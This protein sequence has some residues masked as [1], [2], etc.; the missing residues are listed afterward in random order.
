MHLRV[1]G[2]PVIHGTDDIT[3]TGPRSIAL[4]ELLCLHR[5]AAVSTDRIAEVLWSDRLPGNVDNAIQARVAALRRAFARAG[6]ADP[7]VTEER[8]YRL[9]VDPGGVD[10]DR[11]EQLVADGRR[12]VGAG[13]N[14]AAADVL[15]AALRLWEAAP[16]AAL[17]DDPVARGEVARLEEL[18]VAAQR[19]CLTADLALGRTD[20]VI[21]EA[22][23]LVGLHPFDEDLHALLITALYRAGRQTDALEA[24]GAITRRLRD[25]LGVDPGPA[26][27]QLHQQVLRHDHGLGPVPGPDGA[28]DGASGSARVLPRPLS[29]LVGRTS[30]LE[31]LER[32]CGEHR[33]V[34]LT[35]PGGIGKTRLAIAVAQRLVDAMEVDAHLVELGPVPR[36]AAVLDAVARAIGISSAPTDP[37]GRPVA[38]LAQRVVRGVRDRALVV[39]V[40]NCEHV[41]DGAV[42]AVELLLDAGAE[43]RV[44]ATSREGL[45]IAG[46]HLWPVTPLALP[47]P[48]TCDPDEV[49]QVASVRLFSDRARAASPAFVLD[50]HTAPAVVELVRRLDGLPLAI[51]LAAARLSSVTL[52]MLVDRLGDRFALLTGGARTATR[53]QQTLE[54]VIDWS[55]DLLDT[56]Q[57]AV[58]RRIGVFSSPAEVDAAEAVCADTDVPT[59]SVL[60]V[61]AELVD[62]SL[63]TLDTTG[64]SPRYGMLETIRTYARQRLDA[65]HARAP[66]DRHLA[67]YDELAASAAT[68]VRGGEQVAWLDRLDREHADLVAATRWAIRTEAGRALRMCN[69][70]AWTWWL[71]DHGAEG[72]DLLVAAVDASTEELGDA[73]GADRAVA[74]AWLAFLLLFQRSTPDAIHDV[75]ARV[76]AEARVSSLDDRAAAIV[77]IIGGFVDLAANGDPEV[78]LQAIEAGERHAARAGDEWALAAAAY[79]RAEALGTLGRADE[80]VQQARRAA[81]I[82]A[83]TGD[84]W[85]QF[86]SHQWQGM[87]AALTGAYAAAV[88]HYDQAA[89]L[90]DQLGLGD[91]ASGLGARRAMARMLDGEL[92]A[93][94]QDL[95]TVLDALGGADPIATGVTHHALGQ[96]AHRQGDDATSI[97]HHEVALA[98]FSSIGEDGACGEVHAHIAFSRA[99]L[100]DMAGATADARRALDLTRHDDPLSM[101][102]AAEGAAAAAARTAP[103]LAARFLGRA[104]ALREGQGL[105]LVAGE[106]HDVAIVEAQVRHLAGE[107]VLVRGMATGATVELDRLATELEQVQGSGDESRQR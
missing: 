6:A 59:R 18:R 36:P 61:L 62:K 12:H 2:P 39:V 70:L 56:R 50:A 71:R 81:D 103:D 96:V 85:G 68:G 32:L 21:A 15:R 90:A 78:A 35:G 72:I 88:S 86:Q 99:H 79:C 22:S 29:E 83:S 98:Q 106:R 55:H 107:D 47:P 25:E 58:F 101:A 19:R 11:F 20:A 93:A 104:A 17:P 54:A 13:D 30:E 9:D 65:D 23:R 46:E 60:P 53:R 1:L 67:W 64:P 87:H 77:G 80:A 40:D 84:R 57:R 102:L 14:D 28:D 94:R 74:G 26:L 75:L 73:A 38:P 44:I 27:Q 49:A 7:I 33:L 5:N 100:G 3:V 66:R 24:H 43:I 52:P 45:R 34:T 48:G 69:N 51:E 105:P 97:D 42:E 10:V 41:L 91:L 76:R 8:G 16:Y 82:A 63:V 4:V 31:A 37:T 89:S 92:D 95:E